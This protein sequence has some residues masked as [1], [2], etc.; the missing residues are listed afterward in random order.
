MCRVRTINVGGDPRA[1]AIARRAADRD[2]TEPRRRLFV[3]DFKGDRMASR[4]SSLREE[5]TVL[6]VEKSRVSGRRKVTYEAVVISPVD[7]TKVTVPVD[8]DT[9]DRIQPYRECVTMLIE[10]APDGAARIVRPLRW[11]VDCP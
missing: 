4:V 1:V 11:H 9:F 8:M 7:E 6:T 5:V 2:A 3:L 10:R